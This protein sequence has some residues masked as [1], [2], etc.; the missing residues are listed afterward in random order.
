MAY[1][2]TI[3]SSPVFDTHP[4]PFREKKVL[5]L[6]FDTDFLSRRYPYFF[7]SN[8]KVIILMSYIVTIAS[9]PQLG[10]YQF[11][12]KYLFFFNRIL[13]LH[14][15]VL[16]LLWSCTFRTENLASGILVS[17]TRTRLDFCLRTTKCI[18]L[19]IQLS[20]EIFDITLDS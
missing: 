12:C 2:I 8:Y 4:P 1:K 11:S 19:F 10:T 3:P 18:S 14:I 7:A 15:F 20:W 6:V 16:M 5:S 9:E 13:T 17:Q